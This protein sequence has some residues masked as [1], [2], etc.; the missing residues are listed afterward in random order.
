MHFDFGG[1]TQDITQKDVKVNYI[2]MSTSRCLMLGFTFPH[3][4]AFI[5]HPLYAS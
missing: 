4:P 2:Q 1:I 3:P 5:K